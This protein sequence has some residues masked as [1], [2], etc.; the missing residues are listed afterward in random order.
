MVPNCGVEASNHGRLG[1]LC[2]IPELTKKAPAS[3][4]TLRENSFQIHGPRLFNCLPVQIRDLK[5][6]SVEDFKTELDLVLSK[7]ADEPKVSGSEYTPSACDL[8]SGNPSN[9]ILDQIRSATLP[10][11]LKIRRPGR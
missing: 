11:R 10:S 4:K 8:Y 2:K 7:V 6:C 5:N 3:I 9:S 1:R